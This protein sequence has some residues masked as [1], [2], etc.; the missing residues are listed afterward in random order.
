MKNVI[1]IGTG[2]HAKV[3]AE[4]VRSSGDR[5]IGFI[6]NFRTKGDIFLGLPV[7]GSDEDIPDFA[8]PEVYF[9]LGIGSN[10]RRAQ[11]ASSHKLPWYT[12]IHPS[13]VVA[14]DVIIGSGTVLMPLC[15]VNPN[16]VIGEHCIVNTG[17]IIEHD[18]RIEDFVH[19][20]PRAA[21]A[22]KV[23]VGE[24]THIG[25]GACVIDGISIVSDCIIGAGAA[26]VRDI[27]LS[28]TYVGV[29]ARRL[30]R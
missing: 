8:E 26:V 5:V 19:L 7:L 18:N 9:F 4:I 14:P 17:A 23:C 24:R 2:G 30:D 29:P 3:I 15:V 6:D 11:L 10:Q 1:I 21:L 25:I 13:A 27:G 28:G 16:S 12:A 20:S 22:G